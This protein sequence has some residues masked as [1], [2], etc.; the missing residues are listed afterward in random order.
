M[1]L[2]VGFQLSFE[3]GAFG[4]AAIM[5]GWV[6]ASEIAAHQVAL[7]MAAVTYMAATGIASAAT[8]RVGNEFGKKDYIAVR[9]AG[10]TA[11]TIVLMFMGT[12]ALGFM[13][14]RDVLPSLYVQDKHIEETAVALLLIS[15]FFQLSDGVQVVGLGCLRGIG[16]I[17]IPTC[18]AL[19]AYWVIGLPVGYY[20]AFNLNQGVEGIWY[21]LFLGLSVAA[22]LLLERFNR[23]SKILLRLK[24]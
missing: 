21:G 13:L 5:V 12:C 11:F 23:K 7:N 4:F 3:S 19:V 18:I 17:R 16:D 2:P 6:G 20:F 24:D 8:V 9:R 1:S 10:V 14:F 22:I 15:A